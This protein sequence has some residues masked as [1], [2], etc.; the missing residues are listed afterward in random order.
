MALLK[1]SRS[2][3]PSRC[4]SRSSARRACV[5]LSGARNA[6][7]AARTRASVNWQAASGRHSASADGA[8]GDQCGDTAARARAA[9]QV[10][11]AT[12]ITNGRTGFGSD[13]TATIPSAKR[14]PRPASS[15]AM[16]SNHGRS[17]AMIA[18]TSTPS[19]TQRPSG[20]TTAGEVHAWFACNAERHRPSFVRRQYRYDPVKQAL[21]N[22]TL[23]RDACE[24]QCPVRGFIFRFVGSNFSSLAHRARKPLCIG[25][26]NARMLARNRRAAR[27]T[28]SLP[29]H[30][31]YG[32]SKT[33]VNVR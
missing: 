33:T 8:P 6:L 1:A 31:A 28:S 29:T 30:D 4:C 19:T 9:R 25:K 3:K 22:G 10:R 16:R 26:C 2:P 32:W 23:S 11:R 27:A 18:T 20:Q 14:R 15:A 7:R 21:G 5:S 17:A 12:R 24:E 13:F